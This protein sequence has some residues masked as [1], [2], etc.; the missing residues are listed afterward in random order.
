MVVEDAAWL[1]IKNWSKKQHYA[2]RR[3]PWIKMYNTLLDPGEAFMRLSE[4]DQWQLVRLWL[5]ASR[6]EELTLDEDNTLVPVIA[7]NESAL[8]RA[9]M[10]LKKIPV[11][12]FISDGWL[13]VVHTKDLYEEGE[14]ASTVASSLASTD[15]T[16]LPLNASASLRPRDPETQKEPL[17]VSYLPN[18]PSYEGDREHAF[19][20]LVHTCRGSADARL[21]LT[22]TAKTAA[23]GDLTAALEAARSPGVRD[24]LAIA[25]ST[26][27]SRRTAA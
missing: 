4:Q 5:V 1:R 9:T 13:I 3:P 22:R 7:N 27:K 12:R 24:P 15:A 17:S 19:E 21:K 14:V 20:Q 23:Y 25:L 16:V 6:A 18:P 10:S 8:R 26:L 11:G 2:K